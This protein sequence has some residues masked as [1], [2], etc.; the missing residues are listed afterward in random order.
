VVTGHGEMDSV[1]S[2]LRAGALDFMSKP[3]K[4]PELGVTLE[5]AFEKIRLLKEVNNKNRILEKELKARIKAETTVVNK[6]K[7][8]D[9]IARQLIECDEALQQEISER[10]QT[11]I[12]LSKN[13]EMHKLMHAMLSFTCDVNKHDGHCLEKFF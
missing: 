3:V 11:E 9:D 13:R 12:L 1:V 10:I 2:S 4:F 8:I 6:Q 7:V 5:K